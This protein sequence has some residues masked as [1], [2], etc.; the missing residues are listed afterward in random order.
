MPRK[1]RNESDFTKRFCRKLENLGALVFP[2]VAHARQQ[3]G[4]PDRLIVATWWCGLLEFKGPCTAVRPLQKIIGGRIRDRNADFAYVL[5]AASNDGE[6]GCLEDFSGH[7]ITHFQ[8]A[9]EL[10]EWFKLPVKQ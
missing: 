1:P 2:I 8:S 9:E 4:W 5:R 10:V 6:A 7:M 3:P